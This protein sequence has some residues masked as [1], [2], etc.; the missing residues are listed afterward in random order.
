MKIVQ[1]LSERDGKILDF[2]VSSYLRDGLPVS[3]KAIS[4]SGCVPDSSATIRNVMVRL[5]DNGYLSQP[6]TSSGRVPTDKGLRHYVNDIL[7]A[8]EKFRDRENTPIFQETVS[9]RRWDFSSLLNQAS[10]VLADSSANLGFVI[11]PHISAV[12]FQA[13]RFV[14]ISDEKVLI[15][16]VTPF[17]MVLTESVQTGMALSQQDLDRAAYFINENFRGRSLESVRDALI[18]EMPRYRSR[19]EDMINKLMGIIRA[20]VVYD[21]SE[22]RLYLQGAASLL[23]N[24]DRFDWN[25]LMFLFRSIEERARLV[26]LLSDLISLDGVRVL[27]GSEVDIP[28]IQDCSLVLSHYGYGNQVLGSLGIIGPKRIAYD[29]IIPLVDRVARRLSHAITVCSKEVSI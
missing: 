28:D 2:I 23:E 21:E 4:C 18:K 15:I 25:K 26:K 7:P 14:K 17:N 6:H 29:R 8:D 27:I 24:A 16:V 9:S 11:S 3:S 19:F 12:Q 10:R 5:E 13:V 22:N 1:V 20:S